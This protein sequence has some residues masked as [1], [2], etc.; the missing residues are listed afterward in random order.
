MGLALSVQ[1]DEPVRQP[2]SPIVADAMT[3]IPSANFKNKAWARFAT[4]TCTKMI[5][6]AI[7]RGDQ[8]RFEDWMRDVTHAPN[9]DDIVAVITS[10]CESVIA[11][12][13][14]RHGDIQKITRWVADYE[15]DVRAVVSAQ[16]RSKDV[17]AVIDADKAELA[18]SLVRVVGMHDKDTATHLDAVAILARR[19]ALQMDLAPEVV[20]TIELAGL[21]HDVGKVAVN[22]EIIRKPDELS[23]DEWKEMR[24]HPEAGA[25]LLAGIPKLAFLAPIVR[26][27]HERIDGY[28]Y[29]ARLRGEDI[30]LESR[31]IA[32]ADAF[33]A[34]TTER[35]YRKALLPSDALAIIEDHSGTQFD[36]EVVNAILQLFRYTRRS[37]KPSS[38]AAS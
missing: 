3:R 21:L 10:V 2:M 11:D 13:F 26:A 1:P 15:Q 37:R 32:V 22:P 7:E 16:K 34:M 18:A 24:L 17:D 27:H 35:P 12:A 28:G 19:I 6:E 31:V 25:S 4:E 38:V 20:N 36:A 14:N 29:P 9:T 30:P 8:G 23:A 5:T 33:H